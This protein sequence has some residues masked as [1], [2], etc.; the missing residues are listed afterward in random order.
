MWAA[1]N[2]HPEANPMIAL[3]TLLRTH[4]ELALHALVTRRTITGDRMM[5]LVTHGGDAWVV[6]TLSVLLA[7][8]AVPG[9]SEAGLRVAVAVIVSHLG[10]QILKRCIGRRRPDL[11]V[12]FRSSIEAPDRFSF[13]SGHA[14]A[15]LSVA[16]P[17]LTVA[18]PVTGIAML[19]LAGLV[20]FSRCYLGVHYPGDVLVGWLL[21]V[22][23]T[24]VAGPLLHALA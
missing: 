1:E 23:G 4:D 3:I 13:P 22:V 8:G 7:F 5:R 17:L 12:G 19:G 20:G 6:I 9:W 10:V 15:S 14:A 21:A 2:P 11:P 16:L 18:P 24:W